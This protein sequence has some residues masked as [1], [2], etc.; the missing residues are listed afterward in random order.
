M[1]GG[2]SVEV[3]QGGVVDRF[4]DVVRQAVRVQVVVGCLV[5]R[6]GWVRV[7]GHGAGS[8][9]C[10]LR[11]TPSTSGAIVRNSSSVQWY[12]SVLVPW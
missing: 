1:A 10:H 6:F 8:I 5:R 11:S 4:D 7:V 12:P 2:G 3:W 9:S